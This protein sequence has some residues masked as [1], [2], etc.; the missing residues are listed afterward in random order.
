M[1]SNTTGNNNTASGVNSLNSNTTGGSNFA[2]GYEAL[3]ANVTGNNNTASGAASLFS[4]TNGNSNTATGVESLYG[5]TTG[6]HNAGFGAQSLLENT[7]GLTNVAAGF[8]ALYSNTSG[9]NNI[10]L[11]AE[12][13]YHLTTGSNNVD[14]ANEGSAG[15]SG[16]IRIGTAATQTKVFIAGIEGSKVTGSAVY[17][18]SSGQLGVL[19]SSE[20][21]KTAIAPMGANTQKLRQLRPVSF[22]LRSEPGGPIQYGLIAEEVAKVY[23]ELVVRDGEGRIQG[24]RYDEL[25]PMLLNE[26]QKQSADMAAKFAGQTA[27][28]ES[29][30][31]EIRDL[32]QRVA[33]LSKLEEQVIEMRA[34]LAAMQAP[35][36]LVARR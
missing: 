9:S 16:T 2:A 10:A 6:Y 15:E 18:T 36:Q 25:A 31:A 34:A 8:Q 22:H 7:T 30:A 20:R 33:K 5:N 19:A 1:S 14:I 21:Y 29:Q 23:P 11:G 28:M 27:T 26:M 12:A 32:H 4:N 17:V 13:G 24:V 3:Q 35:D